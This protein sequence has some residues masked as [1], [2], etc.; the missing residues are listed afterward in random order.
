[1]DGG[2]IDYNRSIGTGGNG[3]STITQSFTVGAGGGASVGYGKGQTII[4]P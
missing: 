3:Q 2:M 4:F 1:M